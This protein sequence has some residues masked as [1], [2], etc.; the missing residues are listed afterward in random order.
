MVVHYCLT[1]VCGHVAMELVNLCNIQLLCFNELVS[2]TTAILASCM[3]PLVPGCFR[4]TCTL[5]SHE[6]HVPPCMYAQQSS[7]SLASI[8]PCC[9]VFYWIVYGRLALQ[10]R[11]DQIVLLQTLNIGNMRSND[12]LTTDIQW[13]EQVFDTLPILQV[14]PLT[15]HVEVCNFLSQVLFN[16]E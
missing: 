2:L 9:L 16:C 12:Y 1:T 10:R 13:G 11:T 14:F 3:C 6:R 15:N 8:V 4:F 7:A 5:C